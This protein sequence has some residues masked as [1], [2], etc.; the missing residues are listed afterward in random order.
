MKPKQIVDNILKTV[1]AIPPPNTSLE[2]RNPDLCEAVRYYLEL[3]RNRDPRAAAS[4]AWFYRTHLRAQFNG[5]SFDSVRNWLS[6]IGLATDG[7]TTQ[8][9]KESGR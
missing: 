7:T 8:D 6:R 3:K 5:P 9:T 2:S 1:K 4:L